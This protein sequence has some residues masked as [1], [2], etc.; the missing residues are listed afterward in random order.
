M[1]VLIRKYKGWEVHYD[2]EK[3]Q[4]YSK[5]GEVIDTMSYS[6]NE[7]TT[8]SSIEHR[9]RQDNEHKEEMKKKKEIEKT[10]QNLKNKKIKVYTLDFF[11]TLKS[12]KGFVSEAE[13]K[14][15][16]KKLC[17]TERDP[18]NVSLIH[19]EI[20]C[21]ATRACPKFVL[22]INQAYY[23]L[24]E[25]IDFESKEKH[26]LTI[27]FVA[28]GKD[29]LNVVFS[30]SI[31]KIILSGIETEERDTKIPEIKYKAKLRLSKIEFKKM[32]RVVDIFAESVILETKKSK[33]HYECSGD[34]DQYTSPEK[35]M[36]CKTDQ[37]SKYAI[38][39]LK[40][41]EFDNEEFTLEWNSDFPLKISDNKGN[42]MMLAP[43]VDSD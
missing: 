5:D 34:I 2:T 22:N 17:A 35:N 21:T 43:R 18:A 25:L 37:K 31:G 26:F 13:F 6:N 40:K 39:Y 16:K 36:S 27:S 10:M 4:F 20:P 9:I 33:F 30:N 19:T 14:I 42:F 1:M 12:L 3:K 28:R 29:A 41:I 24:K 23:I 32:L 7:E 11:Q 38:E 8:I 15:D